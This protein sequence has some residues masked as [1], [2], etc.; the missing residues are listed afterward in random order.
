MAASRVTWKRNSTQREKKKE[1]Q[2]GTYNEG[3][4]KWGIYKN[5]IGKI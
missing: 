4:L 2:K 5:K 1:L 3:D